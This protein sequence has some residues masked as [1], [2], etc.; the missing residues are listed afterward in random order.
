MC[1]Y[2]GLI[3]LA[4]PPEAARLFAYSD[5]FPRAPWSRQMTDV[6][7]F[8]S[9]T[10]V[11]GHIARCRCLSSLPCGEGAL[12]AECT[13]SVWT[14]LCIYLIKGKF[15]NPDSFQNCIDACSACANVCDNCSA[16]CLRQDAVAATA[17]C[18]ESHI[19]CAQLCRVT[20]AV[21]SR[22]CESAKVVCRL[23]AE[24]CRGWADECTKR[25]MDSCRLCAKACK[26]CA[27]EC[28]RMVAS[29]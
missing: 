15:M 8:A 26:E 18:I 2:Y 17:R 27:A 23:C 9:I 10:A 6:C 4:G 29:G 24:W 5:I 22:N 11:S 21:L 3:L 16:R 7:I 12:T 19:E 1:N 28:E 25:P 14:V 20:A 13:C